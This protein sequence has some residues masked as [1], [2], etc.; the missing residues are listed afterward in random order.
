MAR[1][2]ARVFS[3]V[4]LAAAAVLMLIL[5]FAWPGPRLL[6]WPWNLG[7]V[8]L[9]VMGFRYI[10]QSR[11]PPETS[12]EVDIRDLSRDIRRPRLLR[13]PA[14]MGL[15]CAAVGIA[16]FLGTAMPFLVAGV[17][18]M[19]VRTVAIREERIAQSNS[20]EEETSESE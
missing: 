1:R 16:V 3:A 15:F 4:I 18:F 5:H 14:L 20:N 10:L 2:P 7:C 17:Y 13:H 8:V 6:E 12:P 11:R 9:F 19:F